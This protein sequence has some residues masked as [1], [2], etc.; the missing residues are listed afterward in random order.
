MNKVIFVFVAIAMTTAV[1]TTASA[2][3]LQITQVDTGNLLLRGWVDAYVS[4][5][6]QSGGF[7]KVGQTGIEGITADF[8]A[9]EREAGELRRLEILDVTANAAGETGI[10]FLLLIDNSG[11]MYDSLGDETRMEYARR[12]LNAFITSMAGSHDRAA[13][14]AFNT[15]LHPLARLGAS[16]GE[17]VRS[18]DRI[19]EPPS[20]MAYTEL[21]QALV[22]FLPELTAATGRKAVIV[23][24]DGEDY[25][26]SRFS[27]ITHPIWEDRTVDTGEVVR[28]YREEE[29]TLYAI[30]FSDEQDENLS[31]IA[32]ETG[33]MV[34]EARDSLELTE[35]YTTIRDSI[36]QEAR[37]RVRIPSSDTTERNLLVQYNNSSDEITYFAPLLLGSP[38][39]VPWFVPL[40]VAVATAGGLAALHFLKI[41]SAAKAPEIRVLGA[42][43]PLRLSEEVTVIG[44][45]PDDHLS[46]AGSPGVDHHHAEIVH[47]E[48][49]GCYTLISDR[50]VRVNN[51]L[52]KNRKL[53]PGDVIGIEEATIVF[54]GEGVN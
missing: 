43:A 27:G 15:Y 52:V 35:V 14:G 13:L 36:Q 17:L 20:E 25:P 39:A 6:D 4:V 23:L 44:S 53:K 33:G 34:F 12:A 3:S 49:K 5:S 31:R 32:H 30:N 29:V 54:D 7:S 24:S 26:F 21:Y 28:R 46:L 48:K 19:E 22:G 8:T 38:G 47:D 16:T 1:A 51:T 2:Q 10:D 37:V 40:L 45:A 41:E 18:L 11:S 42:G 50:P 9:A